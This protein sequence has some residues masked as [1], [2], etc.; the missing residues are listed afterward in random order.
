MAGAA[1]AAA[2]AVLPATAAYA[3]GPL[4]PQA[5]Q[6]KPPLDALTSPF[7][8]TVRPTACTG[9]GS[10]VAGGTY[11]DNLGRDEAFVATQSHGA[12]RRGVKLLLPPNALQNP[13]AQVSGMACIS[14]GNCVAV[15]KFYH[16]ASLDNDALIATETNGKWAR[17]FVPSPPAGASGVFS[18]LNDV[19]CTSKGFCAAVGGYSDKAGGTQAMALVKPVG[20]HWQRAV[21]IVM[22]KGAAD[23]SWVTNISAIACTAVLRCVAVGEYGLPGSGFHGQAMGVVLTGSGWR[24]AV[25]I[26]SPA[27]ALRNDDAWLNGVSCR[28]GT[29]IAA[30]GYNFRSN[31]IGAMWATE[32][33]GRFRAAKEIINAP[34]NAAPVAET[35]LLGI[36]CPLAGRCVAV[37]NYINTAGH[38]VAMYMTASAGR[39]KAFALKPPPSASS[40]SA[41]RSIAYTVACSGNEHCTAVGWYV[42]TAGQLRPEAASTG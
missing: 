38:Q 39:W 34:A 28:S 35:N 23:G 8:A 17:G 21:K 4:F 12:W 29:C 20:K 37:G 40:S 16:D 6:I 7:H 14:A 32:S 25:R 10:C 31:A 26:S 2:L 42:D 33:N 5:T 15:G 1:A 36:S 22:P 18:Y 30:G 41:Q 24:R 19:S 9:N 11:R 13:N 27:N 3:S